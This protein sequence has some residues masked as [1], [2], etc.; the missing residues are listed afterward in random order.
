MIVS[1]ASA[2]LV[3][4]FGVKAVVGAGAAVVGA[5]MVLMTRLGVGAAIWQPMGVAAVM[6][7]GMGAAFGPATASLMGSVPRDRAGV[8][9]AMNDTT[10]Q[11]GGALGVA[12]LGSVLASRYHRA[13]DQA[14]VL[15]R[16]PASAAAAVRPDIGRAVHFAHS[17]ASGGT[18]TAALAVARHGF[19]TAFHLAAMVGAAVMFVGVLVVALWLPARAADQSAEAIGSVEPVGDDRV[20]ALTPDPQVA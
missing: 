17:T 10:R 8:G 20:A 9:S 4:L 19:V 18:G 16:L 5:G 14:A 13:I 1:P 12:V 6:G 15:H 2:R 11:C 3:A 7:V